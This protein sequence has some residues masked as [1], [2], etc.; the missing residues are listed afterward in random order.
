MPLKKRIDFLNHHDFCA[1]E[2]FI[3]ISFVTMIPPIFSQPFA[4][5]ESLNS[6]SGFPFPVIVVL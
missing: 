6:L 1:L 4:A 5:A 2:T 3:S